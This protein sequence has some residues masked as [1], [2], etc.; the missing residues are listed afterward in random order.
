MQ[1]VSLITT[2]FSAASEERG[3]THVH[4]E[5]CDGA[6]VQLFVSVESYDVVLCMDVNCMP[7]NT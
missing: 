7:I 1:Y 3:L 4:L 2:G 6:D 5:N